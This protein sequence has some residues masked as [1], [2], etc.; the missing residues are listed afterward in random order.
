MSKKLHPDKRPDDCEAPER[1][2]DLVTAYEVLS[3]PEKRKAY[4]EY[5]GL[6]RPPMRSAIRAKRKDD[7]LILRKIKVDLS[8]DAMK[9]AWLAYRD[10]WKR[11]EAMIHELEERKIVSILSNLSYSI[12]QY[13]FLFQKFRIELDHKRNAF[14][15]LSAEERESLKDSMRLFRNPR[16]SQKLRG[17]HVSFTGGGGDENHKK[18]K[19]S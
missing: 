3:D 18:T 4:D 19:V 16:Y 14:E 17:P 7:S 9:K 1:F 10:R 13:W 12:H 2:K 11:E 6:N 8:E 5:L 15:H